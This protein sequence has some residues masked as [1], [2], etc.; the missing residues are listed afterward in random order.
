M[1]PAGSHSNLGALTRLGPYLIEIHTLY[2][3]QKKH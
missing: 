3:L 1:E 2:L